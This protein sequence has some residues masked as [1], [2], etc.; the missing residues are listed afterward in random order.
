M[1]ST[2]SEGWPVNV[3]DVTTDQYSSHTVIAVAGDMDLRTYPELAQAAS[4]VP[5]DCTALEVDLSG[6]SFMDS[7]GLNLL[8]RLRRSLETAGGRFVV[9]GL[10]HQ[11]RHLLVLTETYALLTT[12][13]GDAAEGSRRREPRL[14]PGRRDR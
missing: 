9:T 13:T 5:A 14:P 12:G 6:V 11:P 1:G 4:L 10:R 8:L 3:L 7:S 2:P